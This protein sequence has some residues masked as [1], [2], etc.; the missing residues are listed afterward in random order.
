MPQSPTAD[1][2]A[3]YVVSG[4][5]REESMAEPRLVAPSQHGHAGSGRRGIFI[6]YRRTDSQ[7]YA[8]RL[9]DDLRE[10][11]P[12]DHVYR[13][14]DSN[15]A[16]TDY[17]LAVDEA[18]ADSRVVLAMV[19]PQWLTASGTDGAARLSD[20]ADLVRIELERALASGIAIMPVMVGG[21]TMPRSEA[22]PESLQSFTRLQAYRLRDED[23]RYDFGRLLEELEHFGVVPS[24]DPGPAADDR[25]TLIQTATKLVRFER[26]LKATRRRAYDAVLGTVEL[27]RYPRTAA[28]PERA[29]IRFTASKRTVTAKIVDAIPGHATVLLEFTSVSW[30]GAGGGMLAG[31]V[32]GPVALLAAAGGY[33]GLRAL[34]KRF[35]VG[36]LDNVQRV[37]EGR[38]IGEDSAEIPGVAQWREAHRSRRV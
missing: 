25:Q 36:F 37:L 21:A 12:A 16:G 28:D 6:S 14:V 1:F 3:N 11:F 7:P 5:H 29:Q 9:A 18:L 23:W 2:S 17:T 31:L 38:P 8:G 26:T 22:L 24:G 34:D 27:L 33:G 35:A 13:D 32:L 15:R 10:Y 19:G 20:P 4:N 30:K